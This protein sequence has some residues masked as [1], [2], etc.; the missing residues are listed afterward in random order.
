MRDLIRV[1]QSGIVI[2]LITLAL[3][4][5]A[6]LRESLRVGNALVTFDD[7]EIGLSGTRTL[8]ATGFDSFITAE[9]GEYDVQEVSAAAVGDGWIF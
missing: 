6:G 5:F 3:F 2:L 1:I 8:E 9:L 7:F 4:A